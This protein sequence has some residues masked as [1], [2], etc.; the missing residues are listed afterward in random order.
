MKKAFLVR[1][2]DVT[3]PHWVDSSMPIITYLRPTLMSAT[4]NHA[5][6]ERGLEYSINLKLGTKIIIQ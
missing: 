4:N 2:K 3:F 1:K 6:K 5:H